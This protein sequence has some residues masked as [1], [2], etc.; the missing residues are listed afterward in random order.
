M[1]LK[2][3][4][5]LCPSP[6]VLNPCKCD[7]F[8]IMCGGTDA[9]NLKHV[10]ENID[11][12]SG[13]NEKHF[14]QFYLNNTAITEIEENTFFKVTFD[15]IVIIDAK[16]LKLI[17]SH[18]FNSTNMITKVFI[19][20]NASIVNL[21]PNYDLFLVLS[22]FINLEILVVE[23]TQITEI[24]S[25]AFRPI[26]GIQS[27]LS[28]ID[29]DSNKIEKIGDYSFNELENL[30]ILSFNKNPLKLISMNSFHFKNVSNQTFE[31]H[32]N[33]INTLNGSSFAINS[34]F[35][36]QR[37]TLIYLNDDPNL[38]FFDET[39]FRLFFE[40]NPK[41]K[42]ISFNTTKLDC[43]DCRS[44]WLVKESKYLERF[45]YI[46]CLNGNDIRNSIN[47]KNCNHRK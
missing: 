45:D 11:K 1:F 42:I 39:V 38:K 33:S 7:E 22:S 14:E 8:G 21:P 18:A 12:N 25:Y 24:P 35:N 47:F 15:E 41:N 19:L 34:L 44:H 30:K 6:Q 10:F 29:F 9:F 23:A 46:K 27:K 40:F 16:N 31:L 2:H 26:I 32:L 5:C 4:N 20:N 13:E 3:A 43:D 37:P 36:I 17:N 28:R